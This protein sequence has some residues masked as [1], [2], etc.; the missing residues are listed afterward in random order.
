MDITI[1]GQAG[2]KKGRLS[3]TEKIS[4]GIG[5]CGA[6]VIVALASSFLTG[7]YTDTVGIAAAAI[8]T[9]MLLCRVFDGITDLIMGALVDKTKSRFGK[10]RPWLLWTAPLMGIS[11]FLI[12]SIDISNIGSLLK[13]FLSMLRSSWIVFL[14]LTPCLI[15]I[16]TH[17]RY[18]SW[19]V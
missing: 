8:G 17:S 14:A 10:A 18:T 11:L 2:E 16:S 3:A 5:D 9:M 15:R 12:F 7:Y 1:N 4:Y 19:N 13:T 6:N